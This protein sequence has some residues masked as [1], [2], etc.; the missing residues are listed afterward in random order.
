MTQKQLADHL[1]CDVK[2]INRI[3]N[4]VWY[5]QN[6]VVPADSPEN[7]LGTRWM[8]I[9]KQG[10]GIHGSED[11]GAIGKQVTAGCVRLTNSDVEELFDIVPAGTE[12]TIV[13]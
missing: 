2:V 5:K 3:V 7:I 9:D 8:G 4:P 11:P 13:D 6:A 1:G 12:V 10:Y